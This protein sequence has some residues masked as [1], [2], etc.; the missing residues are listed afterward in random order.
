MGV[1]GALLG[2]N[3]SDVS[4]DFGGEEFQGDG[5]VVRTVGVGIH[6]HRFRRPST[7]DV[8]GDSYSVDGV[9]LYLGGRDRVCSGPYVGEKVYHLELGI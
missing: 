6:C 1:A 4:G 3:F 9:S 2:W 8:E 5:P 7:P